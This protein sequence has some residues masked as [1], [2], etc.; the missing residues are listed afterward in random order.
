VWC[1]PT[2]L[3]SPNRAEQVDGEPADRAEFESLKAA[4]EGT[5]RTIAESGPCALP[6]R[7]LATEALQVGL[8]ARAGAGTGQLAAA[9][10]PTWCC[11]LSQSAV[12]SCSCTVQVLR[13]WE[14]P[15]HPINTPPPSTLLRLLGLQA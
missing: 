5:L 15:V 1:Q 4:A 7:A 6:D 2:Q 10:L 13:E 8:F 12:A 9:Q 11:S 14:W 3:S